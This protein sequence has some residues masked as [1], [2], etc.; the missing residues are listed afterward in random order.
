[1]QNYRR[2][3]HDSAVA[4]VGTRRAITCLLLLRFHNVKNG[5]RKKVKEGKKKN[6]AG[7]AGEGRQ[8]KGIGRFKDNRKQTVQ[9]YK[10]E[11]TRKL[12]TSQREQKILKRKHMNEVISKMGI[13]QV[14]YCYRMKKC[15]IVKKIKSLSF[16][17]KIFCI[18][19]LLSS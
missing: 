8:S 4:K 11:Q 5:E 2:M 16:F 6:L 7:C 10:L 17:R 15:L 14:A 18:F 9:D 19:F 3:Y 13:L 12:H 1:M